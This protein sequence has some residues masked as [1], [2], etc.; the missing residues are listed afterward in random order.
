M[1]INGRALQ[2][3]PKLQAGKPTLLSAVRRYSEPEEMEAAHIAARAEIIPTTRQPLTARLSRLDVDGLW[4]VRVQ[5]SGPR[6]RYV[7]LD[8][9]RTFLSFPTALRSRITVGWSEAP[10]GGIVRHSSGQMFYERTHGPTEWGTLSL[11]TS[12]AASLFVATAGHDVTA[13]RDPLRI[14]PKPEALDRFLQLHAEIVAFGE[15][16]P[17][18]SVLREVRRALKQT[19]I[20]AAAAALDTKEVLEESQAQ[21]SHGR[22]L[23]RFR[24]LLEDNEDRPL[25]IP[26]V[27]LA[28]GTPERS[29]RECFQQRLGMSP[30]QYLN[31]RRLHL[32]RRA[33]LKTNRGS[34]VTEIAMQFGFWHLGRFAQ[35]YQQVHGERPS[36]T[37]TRAERR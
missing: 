4:L 5:E 21:R 36:A 35:A 32:A 37:L 3:D 18:S 17:D 23:R 20:E 22:I 34:K 10:T 30:K 31:V 13:P 26:E 16:A 8:P 1:R 25:Y 33:L 6:L 7:E 11:P 9:A 27:C 15:S 24:R 28:I 12:E 2:S 19:M 14:M 29:L